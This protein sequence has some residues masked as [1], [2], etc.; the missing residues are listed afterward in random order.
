MFF[1]TRHFTQYGNVSPDDDFESLIYT[2]HFLFSK[3]SN[4]ILEKL[5]TNHAFQLKVLKDTLKNP[6]F[7]S[8][9]ELHIFLK[10]KVIKY[11]EGTEEKH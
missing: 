7:R 3:C 11:V 1:K 9:D 5:Q 6:N 2:F 4:A 8:C 10:R